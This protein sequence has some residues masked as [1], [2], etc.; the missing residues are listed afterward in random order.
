[1]SLLKL[2]LGLQAFYIEI[3]VNLV[4]IEIIVN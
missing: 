2:L 1:M 3:I 4:Q